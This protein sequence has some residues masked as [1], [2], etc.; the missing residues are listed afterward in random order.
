MNQHLAQWKTVGL[1]ACTL[2]LGVTLQA[3]TSPSVRLRATDPTA[4]SGTTG[5]AFTLIRVGDTNSDLSVTVDISGT[6]VNGV[7]YSPISTTLTLPAGYLAVDVPVQPIVDTVNRGNKTVVLTLESNAAYTILGNAV[8][9]V[10]IVDDVFDIPAPTATLTSPVDGSVAT[11][12]ATLTLTAEV[13]DEVPVTGVS[14][15]V[16]NTF[17]G[18]VTNSPY[19]LTWTKATAGHYAFFARSE[20]QLGKSAVTAPVHVTLSATPVV[21]LGT[22]FGTQYFP[23]E[24]VPLQA[25]VGDPNETIQSAT[26]TVN[27]KVVGTVTSAPFVFNWTTPGVAG[28]YTLQVSAI[29]QATGKKGTSAKVVVTVEAALGN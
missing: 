27:G 5:G 28:N 23:F 4:L 26:F 18:L 22:P 10:K 13:S 12:P 25:L 21:T 11:I 9:T 24:T 17:I 29:D 14:F 16:N 8:A 6:A 15:F 7:D 2:M 1:I 3:Q 20:D 19:T